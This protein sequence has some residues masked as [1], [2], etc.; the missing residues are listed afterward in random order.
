MLVVVSVVPE[1][2]N[3]SNMRLTTSQGYSPPHVCAKI[4]FV[5]VARV[6]CCLTN[7]VCNNRVEE[8]SLDR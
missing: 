8:Q 1:S 3:T 6:P 7:H 2:K 4:D 5:T